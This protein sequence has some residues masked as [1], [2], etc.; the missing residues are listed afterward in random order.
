MAIDNQILNDITPCLG[1]L[2]RVQRPSSKSRNKY[3][4]LSWFTSF[5]RRVIFV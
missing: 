4:M 5:V 3:R 1:R 2:T